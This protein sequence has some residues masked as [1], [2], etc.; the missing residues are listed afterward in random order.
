MAQVLKDEI[1]ENI[2]KGALKEFYANGY[3]AAAMRKIAENAGIPAGLIYSYYKNKQDL[4][5]AV[6]SPVLY[7][8]EQVVTA[9][10]D[11][12]LSHSASIIYGLS[13]AETQCLLNLFEHRREFIIMMDKS[14]GTSYEHE[15]ERMIQVI[16]RHLM[17]HAKDGTSDSVFT[18]IIASNFVDGI[19]Q[20]MYHYKGRDWA[21]MIL[22]KLSKMYLSGIGH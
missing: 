16:E 9:G 1:K 12:V 5:S 2:L 21:V 8:W 4:F 19:M 18:H 10:D 17:T 15:R 13:K 6:L 11:D 22:Q 20:V 3:K 7:D 14:G